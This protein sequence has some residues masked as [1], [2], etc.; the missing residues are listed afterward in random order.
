MKQDPDL[1]FNLFGAAHALNLIN[2][3]EEGNMTR[4]FLLVT[5]V[6]Y[7]KVTRVVISI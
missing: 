7:K 3:N 5:E 4:F 2:G 1:T 6:K